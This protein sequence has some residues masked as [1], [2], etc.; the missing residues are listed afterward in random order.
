MKNKGFIEFVIVVL[1]AIMLAGMILVSPILAYVTNDTVTFTVKEKEN[2]VR[3]D[4][5][6]YLIYTDSEVFENTDSLWYWKWNSSDV[7][8]DLEVGKQYEAEV[9]GFRVPFLSWYRNIVDVK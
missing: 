6:K 9:Y 8:R 7:Y 5:S 2:I 3:N 4:S 1:L